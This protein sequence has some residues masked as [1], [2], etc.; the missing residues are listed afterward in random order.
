MLV[1]LYGA[2]FSFIFL[3]RQSKALNVDERSLSA[4]FM[5]LYEE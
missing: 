4:F 5:V 1:L 2:G 3:C